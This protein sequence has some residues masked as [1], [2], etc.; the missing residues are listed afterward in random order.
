MGTPM[1][2]SFLAKLPLSR[3]E[4]DRDHLTRER[5]DL[6]DELWADPA[7]RVLPV[8]K[9]SALLAQDG[10]LA[11]LPPD[12]LPDAIDLKLYLGRSTSTTSPEPVGTPIVAVELS[13]AR[14]PRRIR[15]GRPASRSATA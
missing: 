1:S 13:D 15:L 11:L 6:F 12:A 5:P 3:Y 9:G 8:F 10:S 7:T 2:Q 14:A 4:I